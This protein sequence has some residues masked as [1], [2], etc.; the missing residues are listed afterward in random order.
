MPFIEVGDRITVTLSET[1][2]LD[3]FEYLYDNKDP[4]I[5]T[6]VDYEL[7]LCWAENCPYSIDL[8]FVDICLD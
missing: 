8:M 2:D 6:G 5:V 7:G 3:L 1:D 4:L